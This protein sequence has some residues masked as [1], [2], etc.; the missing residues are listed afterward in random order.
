M[1][2]LNTQAPA[3]IATASKIRIMSEKIKTSREPFTSAMEIQVF[4]DG[5]P[6]LL[7]PVA[8]V[9]DLNSM[10]RAGLLPN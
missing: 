10:I 4:G 3:A 1:P 8:L 9:R 5:K 6:K 2:Q 7:P